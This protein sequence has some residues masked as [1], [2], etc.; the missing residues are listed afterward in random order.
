MIDDQGNDKR[1][2]VLPKKA[3]RDQYNTI[4]KQYYP[5]LLAYAGLFVDEDTAK[6]IVQDLM[7]YL[8]DKS[9]TLTIHT[10]LESYLF[11]SVYQRCLNTLKHNRV[12]EGYLHAQL[13]NDIEAGY[14]DPDRNQVI[15]EIFSTELRQILQTA[16]ESLPPKCREA[17]TKSYIEGMHTNEIAAELNITERTAE[18]H[19]YNALKHLR[20]MLKDKVYVLLILGI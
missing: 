5:R 11:K 13:L 14:Y 20:V 12:Q 2:N 6:D 19:I 3:D 4:F 18:T 1:V 15:R 16:I 9:D 17:F 7:V 10:S 8:W